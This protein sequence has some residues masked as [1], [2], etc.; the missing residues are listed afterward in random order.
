MPDKPVI[1]DLDA[2]LTKL[3][4][5][6]QEL[7]SLLKSRVSPQTRVIEAEKILLRDAAGAYRGRISVTENG[8]AGLF[9]TDRE[10]QTWA[11]LGINQDGEAFLELK[12]KHGEISYRVPVAPLAPKPKPE[13][14]A[15]PPGDLEP[16]GM[17]AR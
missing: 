16:P 11:R 12:D 2:V 8:S 1:K 13:P 10:G 3:E 4:R 6:W 7:V 15:A 14:P 17:P 5:E 9:L